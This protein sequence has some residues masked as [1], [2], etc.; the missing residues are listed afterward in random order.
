V[1]DDSVAFLTSPDAEGFA[2]GILDAIGDR[3][4]AR[5][6]ADRAKQLADTKYSYEAYLTRTRQA[7]AYLE[8]PVAP[9]VA[10]DIA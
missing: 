9:Q 5:D 6:V 1:L 3:A 8:G 10:G 2:R 4:K 7:C